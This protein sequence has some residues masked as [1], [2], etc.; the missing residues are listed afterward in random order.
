MTYL[1]EFKTI[2]NSEDFNKET[3]KLWYFNKPMPNGDLIL[4]DLQAKHLG[5]LTT[6]TGKM[7]MD[8]HCCKDVNLV[9]C[10]AS[11]LQSD[12]KTWAIIAS[13]FLE[14]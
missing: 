8:N 6:K 10:A 9:A 12:E 2:T 5:L 14:E 1:K 7:F 3:F 11:I 4:K 13:Y